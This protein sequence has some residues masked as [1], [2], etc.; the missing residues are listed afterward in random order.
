MQQKK[1]NIINS[2][3]KANYSHKNPI[4]FLTTSIESSLC[5]YSNAYILV[6]GNITAT[7]NNV[8]TQ[9]IFKNCAPFKDCTTEINDTFVDY[10]DLINIT[11]DMHNLIEYSDNYSD[12]S[13]SLWNFK[14]DEIINNA[15]VINDNNTPSFKYKASLIRNREN[16]GTKNGVKIAVSLKHLSNFWRSLEMPLINCKIEL[17]LK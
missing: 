16:D 4:K 11:M 10:A 7:P 12:T 2:E 15:D 3:S 14:R 8:A 5:D 13:G 17:S 9:V 1:W 6:T